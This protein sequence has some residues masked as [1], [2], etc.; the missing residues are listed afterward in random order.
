MNASTTQPNASLDTSLASP[1]QRLSAWVLDAFIASVVL[2]PLN[3]ILYGSR[4]NGT[5]FAPLFIATILLLFVYL[6][7]FD[8]G[9]R[10]A[11]PGKRMV[12][13]RVADADTREP[14]G[15]RRAAVRRIVYLLGGALLYLGWL[16]LLVDPQRQTWHDHAARS[17]VI[18]DERQARVTPGSPS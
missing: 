6:V 14:I 16:W 8:G 13:I 9:P 4:P 17:L 5:L 18:R 15:F 11:T 7:L 3:P 10:G 2:L 12:G 1:S